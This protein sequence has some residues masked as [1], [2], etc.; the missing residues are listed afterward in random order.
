MD[1]PWN[2]LVMARD[3]RYGLILADPPWTY[4]VFSDKGKDRSAERH[5]STMSL[6]DICALPVR[7]WAAADAHLMMWVTGPGLVRGDHI[8]VMTAW[9]FRPS[10]MAFVWIKQKVGTVDQGFIGFVDEHLFVK[11]MGHTTRQNAEFVVLGRR[12]SPRR[13]SKKTHQIIVAPRREH[14][15]KPD[16]I[17]RRCEEYSDGPFLEMF[18][19]Q[20]WDGWDAF[21]NETD[22]FKVKD[23]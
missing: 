5:Y 14:S 15:R 2:N 19:R 18:A 4:S 13:R 21:G 1:K 8:P 22:K 7:E 20:S 11:G 3:K 16:E 23:A 17:Y 6:S 9:G 12:G 10:S